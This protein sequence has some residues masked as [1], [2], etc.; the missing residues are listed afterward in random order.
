MMARATNI[1]VAT[2]VAAITMVVAAATITAGVVAATIIAAA[3]SRAG[4][5][6]PAYPGPFDGPGS[7]FKEID[8]EHVAENRLYRHFLHDIS[9]GGPSLRMGRQGKWQQR[10]KREFRRQR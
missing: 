5:H 6:I 1:T 3:A 9:R 7:S 8:R 4:N 2:T 10:W